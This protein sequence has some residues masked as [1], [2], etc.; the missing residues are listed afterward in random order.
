[1]K[2]LLFLS[3]ILFSL[4]AVYSQSH[5]KGTFSMQLDYSA[6]AHLSV[7]ESRYNGTLVDV[8][9]SGVATSMVFFNAQYSVLDFLSV[10]AYVGGGSYIEDPE[11]ES[12]MGNKIRAFG[13]DL[14][15]YPVNKDKFNW[16]I[17]TKFGYSTLEIN[18]S[19]GFINTRAN[20]GSG[21]FSG[22]SGFNWYFANF[23]GINFELAYMKHNFLMNEY[24][25]NGN[26]QNISNFENRLD[27]KGI[28]LNIG[29]SFKIN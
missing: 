12:A 3:S 20:F 22:F 10:G 8:D 5:S 6:G 24:F 7:Y 11:N 14:R 23:M 1:M 21:Q 26:S 17:G 9:S 4:N 16:Y 29:L 28:I 2:H 19:A 15:A 13:L 27:V 18:R 25:V